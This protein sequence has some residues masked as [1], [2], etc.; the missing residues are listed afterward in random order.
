MLPERTALFKTDEQLPQNEN[1][2][3]RILI[4]FSENASM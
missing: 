1:E 4:Y 2:L 3:N